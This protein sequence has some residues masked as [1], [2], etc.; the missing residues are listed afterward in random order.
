MSLDNTFE[1][2]WKKRYEEYMQDFERRKIRARNIHAFID[3]YE[4]EIRLDFPGSNYVNYY[5]KDVVYYFYRLYYIGNPISEILDKI[6]EIRK[7]H[8][9][10]AS[11]KPDQYERPSDGFNLE[12]NDQSAILNFLAHHYAK[13]QFLE[14]LGDQKNKELDGSIAGVVS[15][16]EVDINETSAND[17]AQKPTNAQ[18]LLVFHYLQKVN[19]FPTTFD[20]LPLSE[21]ITFLTGQNKKNTY[22]Q[23]REIDDYKKTRKNLLVVR[24]QF[25]RLGMDNVLR[26]I[27]KD[28]DDCWK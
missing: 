15:K 23:L 22:D 24:K 12:V 25:E 26:L 20:I 1:N 17:K 8:L 19:L 27:D 6:L 14:F 21:F 10:K 5:I 28:L 11:E 7:E 13:K 4:G 9:A 2:I 16:N 3:H 18:K